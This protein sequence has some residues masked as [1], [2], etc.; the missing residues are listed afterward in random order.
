MEREA[1][2]HGETEQ[3]MGVAVALTITVIVAAV[4]IALVLV[5]RSRTVQATLMM[6]GAAYEEECY[7]HHPIFNM[8]V[9]TIDMRRMILTI[10]TTSI[11]R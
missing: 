5:I 3:A 10:N 1:K 7:N 8:I 11:R 2:S 6:A 4:V 9:M